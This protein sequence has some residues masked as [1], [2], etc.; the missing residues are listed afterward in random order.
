[1]QSSDYGA[2]RLSSRLVYRY[3]PIDNHEILIDTYRLDINVYYELLV[4]KMSVD[5]LV[6]FFFGN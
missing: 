2:V 1:M 6:C 5:R 3:G 4:V